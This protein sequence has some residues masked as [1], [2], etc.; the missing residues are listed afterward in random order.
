MY[1]NITV[2]EETG[3]SNNPLPRDIIRSAFEMGVNIVTYANMMKQGRT[4]HV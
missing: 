4:Y 3:Y 1:H 2:L